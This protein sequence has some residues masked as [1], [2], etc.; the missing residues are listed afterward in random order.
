[1][2]PRAQVFAELKRDPAYLQGL[3]DCK[4]LARELRRHLVVAEQFS[5][6]HTCDPAKL[7]LQHSRRRRL[8]ES[9]E[10]TIMHLILIERIE[11]IF[12]KD[13]S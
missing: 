1:M 13:A 9:S 5:C 11:T 12:Q 6:K 10:K 3:L 4:S 2:A 8:P 7:C